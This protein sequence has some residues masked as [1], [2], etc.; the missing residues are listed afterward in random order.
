MHLATMYS[1]RAR[2]HWERTTEFQITGRLVSDGSNLV[3]EG[4]FVLWGSR[5][6]GKLRADVYDPAGKPFLSLS[7]DS[8]GTLVYYPGR[9]EAV[10]IEHGVPLGPGRIRALDAVF[11]LRTGFPLRIEPEEIVNGAHPDSIHPIQWELAAAG[12]DTVG[13]RVGM[14]PADLFP[15]AVFWEGGRLQ[16]LSASPDDEYEAWPSGWAMQTAD[17]RWVVEV[18]EIRSPAESWDELWTLRVPVEIDTLGGGPF[19]EPGWPAGTE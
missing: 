12:S 10:F 3:A 19:W 11:L 15:E 13:L 17:D 14:G 1:A 5:S 9:E 16:V 18:R 6:R 8:S 7:C 4:P 2:A